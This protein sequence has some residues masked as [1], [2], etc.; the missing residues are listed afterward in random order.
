MIKSSD[1]LKAFYPNLSKE[2]ID[3]LNKAEEECKKL[4]QRWCEANTKKSILETEIHIL[5]HE[6]RMKKVE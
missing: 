1:T 2:Y 6:Q 4:L 5:M 3:K